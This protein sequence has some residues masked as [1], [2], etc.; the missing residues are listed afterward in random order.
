MSLLFIPDWVIHLFIYSLLI[1]SKHFR[2]YPSLQKIQRS[3][4]GEAGCGPWQ[5]MGASLVSTLNISS[6]ICMERCEAW[7]NC[8]SQTVFE[9]PWAHSTP[10]VSFW[11][12][13]E[14]Q[15]GKWKKWERQMSTDCGP[16]YFCLFPPPTPPSGTITETNCSCSAVT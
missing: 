12:S 5:S 13:Q 7:R 1:N 3:H 2:D 16:Y 8:A 10:Q 15:K 4:C 6:P 14:T 11:N 9:V